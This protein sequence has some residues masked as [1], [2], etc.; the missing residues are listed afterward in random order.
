MSIV[1]KTLRKLDIAQPENGRTTHQDIGYFALP[2][3]PPQSFLSLR[4]VVLLGIVVGASLVVAVMLFIGKVPSGIPPVTPV[5][6]VVKDVDAV[7]PLPSGN[8]VPQENV[9]MGKKTS[10]EHASAKNAIAKSKPGVQQ[11]TESDVRLAITQWAE[12]WSRKDVEPYLACYAGDFS[13]PDGMSRAAWE[14]QRKLRIAKPQSIKVMLK[15]VEVSFAGEGIATVR[16]V[17]DYR[18]DAYRETGTK[19]ELR[20]K[21]ENGRWRIVSEK[22]V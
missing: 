12:A 14:A 21:N 3:Q 9:A 2:E 5:D 10:V 16:L 15:Q 17:Q 4:V 8:I 6:S 18:A 1:E 22:V 20:L 13:T 19:K 7:N 11:G